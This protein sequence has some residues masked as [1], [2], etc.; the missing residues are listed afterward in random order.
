[1]RAELL[2]QFTETLKPTA[3]TKPS[4]NE[5]ETGCYFD[6]GRKEYW[7]ANNRGGWISLNETQFKRILRQRGI[8][9]KVPEGTY[10]SPLDEQLI[11]IQQTCDV[12]YAGALAG[13]R[14]GVYDMGE[15]RILVTESPRII[16]PCPGGW[17]VLQAV[18]DGLLHDPQF[19]QRCYLF[20]WLKVSFETLQTGERLDKR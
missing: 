1:M 18:I 7:T 17:P 13:Q 9:P 4:N 3:T 2:E 10:V 5:A 20:G 6:A 15:R 12:H 14:A 8:S 16:E 11:D 19:D